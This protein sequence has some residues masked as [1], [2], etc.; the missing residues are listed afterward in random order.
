LRSGRGQVGYLLDVLKALQGAALAL[1]NHLHR[2]RGEG[3]EKGIGGAEGWTECR[4]LTALGWVGLKGRNQIGDGEHELEQSSWSTD[5]MERGRRSRT[6]A[7]AAEGRGQKRG[8]APERAV[9]CERAD[10]DADGRGKG[11][12]RGRRDGDAAGCSMVHRRRLQ[13]AFC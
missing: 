13:P 4:D 10:D 12:V 2:R 6:G 9:S 1:G 3:A 8:R 11:A 7:E 5:W